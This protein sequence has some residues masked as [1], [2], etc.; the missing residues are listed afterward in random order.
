MNRQHVIATA[1]AL[2]LLAGTTITTFASQN[3][4]MNRGSASAAQ[5]HPSTVVR[6]YFANL[7]QSAFIRDF[8][9]LNALYAPNP[10]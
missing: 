2:L 10:H 1:F 9:A 8:T 6:S 5:F 3:R 7:N 4:T